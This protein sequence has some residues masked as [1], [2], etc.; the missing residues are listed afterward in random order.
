M[1]GRAPFLGL[2]VREGRICAYS[3]EARNQ[4]TGSD[5]R[6][7]LLLHVTDHAR[8]PTAFGGQ[9]VVTLLPGASYDL[10]WDLG[11]Y[12]DETH[13]LD[14]AERTV[15]VPRLAAVVG[16]PLLI[17]HP[18]AMAVRSTPAESPLTGADY[19]D[20]QQHLRVERISSG[21]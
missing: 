9:A 19:G 21:S 15:R 16:E 8:H 3:V 5:V 10:A 7:H 20:H 13:F 14:A 1:H 6:G 2:I 12:E 4:F 18:R 17:E 11:W